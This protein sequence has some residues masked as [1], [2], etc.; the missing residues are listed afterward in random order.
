M[1][2]FGIHLTHWSYAKSIPNI[3]DP[4]ISISASLVDTCANMG[5]SLGALREN[6]YY[7]LASDTP[8]GVELL[9]EF[10]N[11]RAVA[12]GACGL[13]YNRMIRSKKEQHALFREHVRMAKRLQK[14]M[15]MFCVDA[16]ADFVK[17]LRQ[18]QY[19]CGAVHCFAGI[20]SEAKD[21]EQ[22]GIYIAIS[23]QVLEK[24]RNTGLVDSLGGYNPSLVLVESNAPFFDRRE[25]CAIDDVVSAVQQIN[26]ACTKTTLVQ[27]FNNFI[28]TQNAT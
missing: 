5:L 16:H 28:G 7:T 1:H 25:P 27:N 12:V 8:G 18:E 14:P 15:H 6:M 10:S 3:P 19:T 2:D 9:S 21:L 24:R 23:P 11:D 20:K 13:D 26:E 4:V 17:I 22:M